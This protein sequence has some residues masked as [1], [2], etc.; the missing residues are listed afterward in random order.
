M[1]SVRFRNDRGVYNW[2]Q[3]LNSKYFYHLYVFDEKDRA[4]IEE[5]FK[6]IENYGTMTK[7]N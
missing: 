5:C 1:N 7:G 6:T 4:N 3:I 2:F